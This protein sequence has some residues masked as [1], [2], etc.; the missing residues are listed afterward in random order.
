MLRTIDRTATHSIQKVTSP[1]GVSYQTIE[2]AK[3][4]RGGEA[5]KHNSLHAARLAVGK[6][7]SHPA[8]ETAGR[9][10]YPEQATGYKRK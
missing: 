1:A 2:T 10:R 4:G 7:I 9:H 5:I 8:R 3:I 6:V